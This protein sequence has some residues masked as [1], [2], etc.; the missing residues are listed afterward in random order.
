MKR[1]RQEQQGDDSRVVHINVGGTVYSTTRET[2]ELVPDSMLA[3]ILKS[4]VPVTMDEQGRPF[5]DRD[6][7]SFRH[8]LNFLRTGSLTCPSDSATRSR[9]R[10]DAD[11]YGLPSLLHAL[12]GRPVCLT[13]E[14]FVEFNG[15]DK[16]SNGC[17]KWQFGSGD[18]SIADNDTTEIPCKMRV[19]QSGVYLVMVSHFIRATHRP[20]QLYTSEMCL[21]LWCVNPTGR[22]RSIM[23]MWAWHHGDE[24]GEEEATAT[25]TGAE[26][27]YLEEGSSLSFNYG[28]TTTRDKDGVYHRYR[29]SPWF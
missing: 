23:R 27:V 8:V 18:R 3:M 26:I 5:I 15:G 22:Y 4:D 25:A 14:K 11:Y 1:A 12:D 9:L 10:S 7:E 2:L 6:G 13:A 20:K 28:E 17:W 19:K 24:E 21:R 16:H 29:M